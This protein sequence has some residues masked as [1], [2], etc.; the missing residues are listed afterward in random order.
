MV[1]IETKNKNTPKNKKVL[2]FSGGMDSLM[3]DKLFNPDILL[4]FPHGQQYEEVEL[5][6]IT[7][8]V[9]NGH[10]DGDKLVFDYRFNFMELERDDAIIPLRNLYFISAATDYG[11]EILLGSVSGD[12]TLDK[13][14]DFYKLLTKTLNYLYQDQH[15]CEKR[16]FKISS[17]L[18]NFS[19]SEVVEMYLNKGGTKQALLDSYSCYSG[20]R[21]PDGTC[22]ACFRKFVALENNGIDTSN[23]FKNDPRKSPWLPDIIPYVNYNMWRGEKEDADIRKVLKIR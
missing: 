5:N 21:I 13:S 8:L 12:R 9:K 6:N 23:Y 18:K 4:V 22:K 20:E 10:I 14:N 3:M 2:L 7:K 17:P 15:W 11:E 16:K 19:K 1:N